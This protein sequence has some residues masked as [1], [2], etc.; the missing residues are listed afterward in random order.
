ME[1]GFT[2]KALAA[3]AR[4]TPAS[5]THWLNGS[6]REVK[7]DSAAGLQAL[8]GYSA[9]WIAVG[10]LPK[11]AAD[12]KAPVSLEDAVAAFAAHI[13]PLDI[14]TRKMVLDQLRYLETRPDDHARVNALIAAAISSANRKAA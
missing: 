7:G 4:K 13:E 9:A 3:A 5:V 8:T 1:A 11:M 6:S 2:R 10:K 14:D 12:M